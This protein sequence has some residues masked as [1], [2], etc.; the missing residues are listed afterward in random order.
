MKLIEQFSRENRPPEVQQIESVKRER[1]THNHA[2]E[3][4]S[5]ITISSDEPE[6]NASERL[7]SISIPGLDGVHQPAHPPVEK[8]YT[9]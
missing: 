3:L 1:G 8:L 7:S 5:P 9:R 6:N 4:L 2:G